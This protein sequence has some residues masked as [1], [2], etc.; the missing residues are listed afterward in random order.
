M[1]AEIT[2]TQRIDYLAALLENCPHA[3]IIHNDDPAAE[4]F[5]GWTIRVEGC[6][7]SVTHGKT[8]REC[9]DREILKAQAGDW[10]KDEPCA[11][12][13]VSGGHEWHCSNLHG[14]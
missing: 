14:Y 1:P 2:D 7:T 6:Q 10:S 5:V 3:E 8:I 12:C 4:E 11:E 13:G 9:I